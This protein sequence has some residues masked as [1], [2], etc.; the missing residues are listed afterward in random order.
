MHSFCLLQ[1]NVENGWRQDATLANSDSCLKPLKCV[2]IGHD[3]AGALV[4]HIGLE[5]FNYIN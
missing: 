2:T 5:G 3:R 1:E 4:I